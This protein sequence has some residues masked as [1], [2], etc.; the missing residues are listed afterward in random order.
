M[1]TSCYWCI[2]IE[3][4]YLNAVCWV[5]QNH[6]PPADKTS[7]AVTIHP[8]DKKQMLVMGPEL[9]MT[10]TQ[11]H[12]YGHMGVFVGFHI[13]SCCGKI[14]LFLWLVWKYSSL[15]LWLF[16]HP[17]LVTI[18]IILT[19][20]LHRVQKLLSSFLPVCLTMSV[21]VYT[22]WAVGRMLRETWLCRRRIKQSRQNERAKIEV[23]FKEVS[24]WGSSKPGY[25][26]GGLGGCWL[27][28]PR[29]NWGEG[30]R[31]DW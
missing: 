8:S 3:P 12:H 24:C 19:K 1:I 22:E 4:R 30:A 27:S 21:F 26:R 2:L 7:G 28:K 23:K 25:L 20:L 17:W 6:S 9:K 18:I 11:I 15:Y 31:F 5:N 16:K 13:S 14:K 29:G 10:H